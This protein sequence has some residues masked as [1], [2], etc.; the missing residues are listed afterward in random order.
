MTAPDPSAGQLV[1]G[2]TFADRY[3]VKRLL[4]KGGFGAVYLVTNEVGWSL[5]LKLLHEEISS[6]KLYRE[7]FLR[8]MNVARELLHENAVPVRDAGLS[9][10]H[11]YY[12]MDHVDGRTATSIVKELGGVPHVRAVEW[13][14]QILS[15]LEFLHQKGYIHRDMKPDNIMIEPGDGDGTERV[16]VLDL[17]IAKSAAVGQDSAL[18]GGS[19]L[20]SPQF[21]SPEQTTGDEIDARSDLWSTASTLYVC[22]SG[23]VPFQATSVQKL[24]HSIRDDEPTPLPE[25]IPG[26]PKRLWEVIQRG[27]AKSPEDRY[28]DAKSFRSDLRKT[29]LELPSTSPLAATMD[30][31][32]QGG[33]ETERLESTLPAKKKNTILWGATIIAVVVILS[34]VTMIIGGNQEEPKSGTKI[35]PED[36]GQPPLEAPTEKLPKGFKKIEKKSQPDPKTGWLSPIQEPR[37]GLILVLVPPTPKGG[38]LMGGAAVEDDSIQE[39][40]ERPRHRVVLSNPYYLGSTEVTWRQWNKLADSKVTDSL[41]N[42]TWPPLLI[43]VNENHPVVRVQWG[44]ANSF[45]RELGMRLPTEAEWEWACRYECKPDHRYLWGNEFD[46]GALFANVLDEARNKEYPAAL[47]DV[48][49]FNDGYIDTA[50]VGSFRPTRKLGIFDLLGNVFE[51]C[52]D[53]FDPRYYESLANRGEVSVN[54]MKGNS[55]KKKPSHSYRGGS[56]KEGRKRGTVQISSRLGHSFKREDIGFRVCLEITERE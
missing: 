33:E 51:W 22:L 2:S 8:E 32:P 28:P 26:V 1:L 12:T 31:Q 34:G 52:M 44:E 10:G 47:N 15:F 25:L 37:T 40:E 49:R 23:R 36:R 7:R 13:G 43:N 39:P 16:R 9:D 17:G 54:P 21:M 3:K 27:M 6:A 19:L 14:T 11:L 18:T 46:D 41:S 29:Q 50:P 5:A 48:A 24:F 53:E 4:G 35:P 55:G 42:K 56:Y 30:M 20:G 38:F 45:C